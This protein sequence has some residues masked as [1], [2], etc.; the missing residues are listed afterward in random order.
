MATRMK[1]RKGYMA[2]KV[3]MSKAYDRVKW[4]FLEG[5]MR[6]L[7]FAEQWIKLVMQCVTTVTYSILVNGI[8]TETITPS[9]GIRQGDPLSPYLFLLCAECLSSLIANAETD[10]R[11]SGVPVAVNGFRLSHLFFADDSLLFCRANFPEWTTMLSL[12]QRYELASG[13]KLNHAK[14]SIFFQQEHW[15]GFP[16]ID[17][18]SGGGNGH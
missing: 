11:I 5:I 8:P 18:I 13:Q 12:I 6:R 7:G 10:G 9:R 14:T 3:D 15:Q 1:G 16:G 4:S 2:I 17:Q